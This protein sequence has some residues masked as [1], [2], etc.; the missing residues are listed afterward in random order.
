[1]TKAALLTLTLAS[2]AQPAHVVSESA[3]IAQE[4]VIPVLIEAAS[5]V[6]D[7]LPPQKVEARQDSEAEKEAVKLVVKWE[8]GDRA[9]YEKLYQ[10]VICPGGASGATIGIGYDLGTQTKADIRASWGW[11]KD[12]EALVTASGQTGAARCKA[13]QAQH[14]AI[15]VKYD[16]ALRVFTLQDWPTYVQASE[17][18]YKRGWEDITGWHQGALASNGYNRGFSFT[19]DRRKELRVIRDECVP[20]GSAK[21]TGEQLRASCRVWEGTDI[22]KGICARRHDEASFAERVK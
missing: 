8:I 2:C 3:G 21:C 5:T 6:A 13:W 12:I 4:S 11:H 9:R 14:K 10:G 16:D 20:N 19:G 15:R 7:V 1:M 22:Y 18:A 17:R